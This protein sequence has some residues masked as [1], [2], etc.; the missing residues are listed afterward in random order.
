MDK[1]LEVELHKFGNN[2]VLVTL[3]RFDLVE[4]ATRVLMVG[5]NL[6][7]GGKPWS[8]LK[9]VLREGPVFRDNPHWWTISVLNPRP[10]LVS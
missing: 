4:S 9:C 8:N 7:L 1:F 2:L 6:Y 10:V 5:I 3:I